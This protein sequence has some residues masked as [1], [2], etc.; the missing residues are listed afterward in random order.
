MEQAEE[1]ESLSYLYSEDEL[2]IKSKSFFVEITQR[3]ISSTHSGKSAVYSRSR[4]FTH[5]G[6]TRFALGRKFV[7]IAVFYKIDYPNEKPEIQIISIDIP[8]EEKESLT[9]KLQNTCDECMGMAMTYV[10]SSTLITL[11]TEVHEKLL[12]RVKSKVCS[13]FLI[14]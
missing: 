6:I 5:K 7:V 2:I 8:N 11:L 9:E 14:Q 4:D 13:Y 3:S 1:L 12:E 10:L